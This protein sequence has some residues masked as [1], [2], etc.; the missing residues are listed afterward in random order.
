M[1]KKLTQEEFIARAKQ[2]HGDKYDYSKVEYVNSDTKVTIICPIHGVFKQ[3]PYLHYKVGCGCPSCGINTTAQKRA[4][5]TKKFIEKALIVHGNKYGYSKVDYKTKKDKVCITCPIHGDFWQEPYNHLHGSGCPIC[6]IQATANKNRKDT[7]SFIARS[8]QVHGNRYVYDKTIYV[9][10]HKKVI[11]TCREHGDFLQE[12]SNHING[13]GCP[14]C[15]GE[16]ITKRQTKTIDDFIKEANDVHGVGTY[17]YKLVKY[18]G[19]HAK[20]DIICPKHGIF[21]QMAYSHLQGV[22]CPHCCCSKGENKTSIFL[23]ACNVDYIRQYKITPNDLFCETKS[24]FVD[25]YIPKYNCFIEFN[26]M[27]H[28]TPIRHFGGERKFK[29]QQERDLALRQYC[30]RHKIKL[31]EISYLDYDNIET[32]L[33]KELKIHKKKP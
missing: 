28:Y 5:G 21:S 10:N 2:V 14:M 26:G 32:I 31:I 11:I 9:S 18:T 1:P 25:F 19:G 23:D 30:E 6:G 20:V 24:F 29:K 12:P 15:K 17:D 27:Q 7:E 33:S 16:L 4:I 13:A 8:R 22:G 3:T